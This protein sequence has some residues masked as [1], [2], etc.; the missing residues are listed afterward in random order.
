MNALLEYF[1]TFALVEKINTLY[2]TSLSGNNFGWL[3]FLKG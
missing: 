2:L 3:E 1:H